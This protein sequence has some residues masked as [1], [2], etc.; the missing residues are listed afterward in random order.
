MSWIGSI[1]AWPRILRLI[2]GTNLNNKKSVFILY[3]SFGGSGMAE[4]IQVGLQ[5]PK[6][7]DFVWSELASKKRFDFS[8]SFWGR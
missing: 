5:I 3:D 2:F 7:L 8:L 1:V 6:F 4:E